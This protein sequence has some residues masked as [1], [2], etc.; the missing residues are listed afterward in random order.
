MKYTRKNLVKGLKKVNEQILKRP[1][2]FKGFSINDEKEFINY[3]LFISNPEKKESWWEFDLRKPGF[4]WFC[5]WTVLAIIGL[6]CVGGVIYTN[7][8]KWI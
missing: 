6:F 1:K 2:D 7:L 4:W 5:F 8:D 3:L